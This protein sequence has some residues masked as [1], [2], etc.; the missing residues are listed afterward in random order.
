MGNRSSAGLLAYHLED[1]SGPR[2]FLAHM[3]GPFWSRRDL[4]AWSIPKGEYDP[5][6][7]S[8]EA[9]A[10]REFCEEIGVA[11]P[12]GPVIDLAETVQPGGKRV[13]AFAVL[14]SPDLA[15]VASNEFELEWPRGSGVLRR[16][17]EMDA[18]RWFDIQQARRRILPGQLPILDRLLT[19][20]AARPG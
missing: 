5:Q 11:A 6:I 10:R 15:F 3:G 1:P 16:F 18:G 12:A 2:V 8:A 17:P 7:E 9:A 20:L 13:R 19:T 4:G 14:A